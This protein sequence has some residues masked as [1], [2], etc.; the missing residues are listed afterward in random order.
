MS[1]VSPSSAPV[2]P[3]VAGI[4]RRARSRQEVIAT[5]MAWLVPA[6][7]CLLFELWC[8]LGLLLVAGVYGAA[9]LW[10]DRHRAWQVP[11]RQRGLPSDIA[12]ALAQGALGVAN[13][14]VLLVVLLSGAIELALSGDAGGRTRGSLAVATAVVGLLCLGWFSWRSP[15]GRLGFAHRL[16]DPDSA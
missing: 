3:A 6:A 2:P 4:L 13:F 8:G 15:A 12:R 14:A 7:V 1:A 11:P 10:A 5:G 16:R 9:F